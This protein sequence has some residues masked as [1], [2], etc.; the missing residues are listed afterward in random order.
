MKY[1]ITFFIIIF[2]MIYFIIDITRLII[3]K[4]ANWDSLRFSMFGIVFGTMLILERLDL[5]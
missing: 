1:N 4:K 3:K 5:V 2:C